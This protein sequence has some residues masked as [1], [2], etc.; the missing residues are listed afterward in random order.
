MMDTL[1]K[2]TNGNFDAQFKEAT[3]LGESFS[4]EQRLSLQLERIEKIL[5]FLNRWRGM[6]HIPKF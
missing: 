5:T 4:R 2:Q 1:Y 6:R 3:I